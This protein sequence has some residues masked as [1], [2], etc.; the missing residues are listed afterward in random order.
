M[1]SEGR[2]GLMMGRQGD[3][4]VSQ[5]VMGKWVS[6]VYCTLT[7]QDFASTELELEDPREWIELMTP[8][9]QLLEDT[10]WKQEFL[11][12]GCMISVIFRRSG[13]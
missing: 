7:E 1:G 8:R 2:F 12:K 3:K 6:E 11:T 9:L 4:L 13:Y 10:F 5:H